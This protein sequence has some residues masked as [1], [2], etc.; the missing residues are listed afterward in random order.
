MVLCCF[1][2]ICEPAYRA[3]ILIENDLRWISYLD[4]VQVDHCVVILAI[5][6]ILRVHGY[7]AALLLLNGLGYAGAERVVASVLRLGSC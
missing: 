1:A 6:A 4:I 5:V 2:A 7:D 3:P